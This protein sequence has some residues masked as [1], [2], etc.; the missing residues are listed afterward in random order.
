MD[1]D[2]DLFV[3]AFWVKC[4][5]VIRPEIDARIGDLRRAG[6]DA[7][8]AT[9]E[10]SVAGDGLPAPVGPSVTLAIRPID[11]T[12]DAVHPAIEFH[13]DV[14]RQAIDVLTDGTRTQ[15][16]ELAALGRAEVKAEID[17]WLAGRAAA[18]PV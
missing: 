13:G 18:A 7:N 6:H 16:Y 1:Q 14:R 5:E 8:V 4:R 9:Q 2:T 10:F 12:A 17:G 3:Q 11:A 15:S